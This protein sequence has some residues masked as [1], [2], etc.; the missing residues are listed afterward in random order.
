VWA[1]IWQILSSIA[2]GSLLWLGI[3]FLL[4]MLSEASLPPTTLILQGLLILVG[5]QI[6]QGEYIVAL[7]P[8]LGTAYAG[9]LCG[10]TGIF[11]LSSSLGGRIINKFGRYIRINKKVTEQVMQRLGTFALPSI[12]AVRFIPGCTTA[13]SVACGFSRIRYK[14][15]SV[16]VTMHVLA[17]EGIFLALGALGDGVLKFF[18]LQ[19]HPVFIGIAI[20]VAMTAGLGYFVFRRGGSKAQL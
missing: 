5:F 7:I 19:S 2:V 12:I 6:A 9:R 14:N 8:F 4:A 15:F 18:N 13:S 16:A 17:W 11:W 10:S 1:N 3:I 20:V